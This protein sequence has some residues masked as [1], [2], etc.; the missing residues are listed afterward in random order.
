M[1]KAKNLL[2]P[3]SQKQAIDYLNNLIIGCEI[4]LQR[5]KGKRDC[6]DCPDLQYCIIM[7]DVIREVIKEYFKED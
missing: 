1:E 6:G 4:G 7:A 2:Q 3:C 5:E